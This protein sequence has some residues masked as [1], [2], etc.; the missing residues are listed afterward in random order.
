MIGPRVGLRVGPKAGPAA[1]PGADEIGSSGTDP[2]AG[3]S[4]D[5][6][7][8]KYVPAT[9]G[10]WTTTLSVAGIGSGNPSA[11]WLM[12]EGAG[13]TL[14]DSVGAFPL[15]AAG[16]VSYGNAESGWTRLF[17]GTS[18]GVAGSWSSTDAALP[19]LASGDVLLLVYGNITATPGGTRSLSELGVTVPSQ[20]RGTI[21]P[22]VQGRCGGNTALGGVSMTAAV[23]PYILKF[24]RTNTLCKVYTDQEI[25]TPAFDATSAG[26]RVVVGGLV[27]VPM[28]NRYGY[29]AMFTGAAARLSDANVRS[30]LQT[31]SWTIPW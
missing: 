9:A 14:A 13:P 16:T 18:D 7:S 2:M 25:V 22:R 4:R 30:L 24:D 20:V 11:T 19:D 6:T 15:T 12:N 31:L 29:G 28:A 1:G 8:G 3:V 10:Q 26:K 5:S 21:T 23:R 17:V 27:N